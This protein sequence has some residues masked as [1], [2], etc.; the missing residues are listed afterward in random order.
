[1]LISL[2]NSY[3]QA[4][5]Q[6]ESQELAETQHAKDEDRK[7]ER[8]FAKRSNRL[9]LRN[10]LLNEAQIK[11]FDDVSYTSSPLLQSVSKIIEMIKAGHDTYF[12]KLWRSRC[13]Y[14]QYLRPWWGPA[15]WRYLLR[16]TADYVP[17]SK[18]WNGHRVVVS[19]CGHFFG[20]RCLLKWLQSQKKKD[21]SCP[22][23]RN[24][25]RGPQMQSPRSFGN[26]IWKVHCK[27]LELSERMLYRS[28]Y[29]IGGWSWKYDWLT[30]RGLYKMPGWNLHVLL[31]T[32]IFLRGTRK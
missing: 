29:P 7:A 9:S 32:N 18:W 11:S 5:D 19:S 24:K 13:W 4:I 6:K 10:R 16:S 2:L 17:G 12:P 26:N 28:G 21:R 25:F 31:A 3:R 27:N 14:N 20:G 22:M 8:E 23:C 15:T 1:M 30:H